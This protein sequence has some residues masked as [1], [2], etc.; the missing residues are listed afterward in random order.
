MGTGNGIFSP[1][2]LDKRT[3]SSVSKLRWKKKINKKRNS[4]VAIGS[5][6]KWASRVMLY[7]N[8]Q[9]YFSEREKSIALW[10]LILDLFL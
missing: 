7:L 6:S 10:N 1:L 4:S 2:D 5:F 3:L 8:I 9:R